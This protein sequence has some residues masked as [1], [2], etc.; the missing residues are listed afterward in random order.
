MSQVFID[1]IECKQKHLI[2]TGRDAFIHAL[3]FTE[4]GRVCTNPDELYQFKVP[5]LKA[6]SWGEGEFGLVAPEII[7]G[8]GVH[9][10]CYET[11]NHIIFSSENNTSSPLFEFACL[12][13]KKTK[14]LAFFE[15]SFWRAK[16]YSF[17]W[18][19][20]RTFGVVKT[21]EKLKHMCKE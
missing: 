6:C 13:K 10:K 19:R 17:W 8:T 16:E 18:N 9:M 7:E 2:F 5:G 3:Y 20:N 14:L 15:K 21:V 4:F 12:Y 1:V 11:A